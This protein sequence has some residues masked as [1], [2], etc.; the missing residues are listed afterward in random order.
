MTITTPEQIAEAILRAAGS[1]LRHYEARTRT[2]ILAAAQV[3]AA[4]R[5][6][7]QAECARLDAENDRLR[8][9]L[10]VARLYVANDRDNLLLSF[11]PPGQINRSKLDEDEAA[12][13]QAG[14]D[15]LVVVDA[16]LSGEGKP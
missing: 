14:D 11:C 8:E 16:A 7:A 6:T 4:D 2:E 15:V 10:R 13:V 9:A 1:S 5:D 3:I 12:Y